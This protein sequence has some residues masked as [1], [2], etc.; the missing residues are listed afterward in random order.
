MTG[1]LS[2]DPTSIINWL[3]QGVRCHTPGYGDALTSLLT[4]TLSWDHSAIRVHH[5]ATR[6]S[7]ASRRTSI[8]STS[9]RATLTCKRSRTASSKPWAPSR[10]RRSRRRR[11][12]QRSCSCRTAMACPSSRCRSTHRSTSSAIARTT[13]RRS[14]ECTPSSLEHRYDSHDFMEFS[15]LLLSSVC[16][17]S[18]SLD[19]DRSGICTLARYCCALISLQSSSSFHSKTYQCQCLSR[20]SNDDLIRHPV[21]SAAL[22]PT[23]AVHR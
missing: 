1:I 9:T 4:P 12:A 7:P 2:N 15:L 18:P 3:D 23:T 8:R 20:A 6:S 16:V 17:N 13:D 5:A 22:T 11:F 10:S 14:Q 21:I 19:G